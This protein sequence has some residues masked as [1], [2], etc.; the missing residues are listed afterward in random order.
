MLAQT[1]FL[2]VVIAIFAT[3]AI[4]GIAGYARAETATAA[5]A[6]VVPAVETALGNYESGVVVPQVA[7]AYALVAGDGSVVPGSV[8][9]LN[10]NYPWPVMTYPVNAPAPSPLVADVTITPTS[11]AAPACEPN[12]GSNNMGPDTQVNGQCSPFVQESRLSLEV[13]VDVGPAAGANAVSPLAHG[14]LVVTL[15]LFAQP[16]YVMIAG[17]KDDPAPGD[18]HEGDMG[19]YGNALNAFGNPPPGA[20]DTTIHVIYQCVAGSGDCTGSNPPPLDRPTAT[21]WTNGNTTPAD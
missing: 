7:A 14:R 19:G 1:L 17:V 12:G 2:M 6:F 21:P 9:Q 18:P 4:A 20:D 15:R 3:S 5:K 16:P 11:T 10:G 8:P 13:L